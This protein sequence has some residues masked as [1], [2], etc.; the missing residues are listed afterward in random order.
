MAEFATLAGFDPGLHLVTRPAILVKDY[1]WAKALVR[2]VAQLRIVAVVAGP[3]VETGRADLVVAGVAID[4]EIVK[5]LLVRK[6]QRHRV[7][8]V[9]ALAALELHL[10]GVHFVVEEEFTH[11]RRPSSLWGWRGVLARSLNGR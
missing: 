5:V 11:D 4:P 10:L 9:V 1:F 2:D 3:G 6:T 7:G 8:L